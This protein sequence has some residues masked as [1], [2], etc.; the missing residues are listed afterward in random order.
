MKQQYYLLLT[1][2][3]HT[4]NMSTFFFWGGGGGGEGEQKLSRFSTMLSMGYP[5]FTQSW[6]VNGV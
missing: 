4:I 1:Q 6:K 5:E 2:W 3:I